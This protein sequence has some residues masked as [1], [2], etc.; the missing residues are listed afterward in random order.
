MRSC[1]RP[2][3]RSARDS[4]PSSVS[5]RYSLSIRTQGSSCRCRASSSLR[6]VSAFSA[7]SNPNSEAIGGA[8]C[9]LVGLE[10]VHLVDPTPG[11][12]LPLPRQ[13]VATP[14]QRLLGL[15]QL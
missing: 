10:A 12:L 3:K 8:L 1:E 4:V 5:R 14:R 7:R 9:P 2:R 13:L 6:P 15:E 11:Q